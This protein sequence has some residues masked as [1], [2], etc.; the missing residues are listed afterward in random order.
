MRIF[1]MLILEWS[2]ANLKRGKHWLAIP[3]ETV[4]ARTVNMILV[5]HHYVLTETQSSIQH[6]SPFPVYI[7]IYSMMSL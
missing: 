4:L 2:A 6:I 5:L 7:C 1:F 3:A